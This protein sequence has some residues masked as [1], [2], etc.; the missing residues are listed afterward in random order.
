MASELGV[1]WLLQKVTYWECAAWPL[2]QAVSGWLLVQSV[3]QMPA[4]PGKFAQGME[5]KRWGQNGA[6][7]GW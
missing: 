7:T 1:F 5:E 6:V 4:G 3:Q 2:P